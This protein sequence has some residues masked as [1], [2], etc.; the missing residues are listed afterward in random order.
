MVFTKAVN[1]ISRKDYRP[2][3]RF[4]GERLGTGNLVHGEEEP[5]SNELDGNTVGHLLITQAA[6]CHAPT[7]TKM[8]AMQA[9]I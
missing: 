4:L 3:V 6:A 5:I 2:L 9:A 7:P 8:W 1:A